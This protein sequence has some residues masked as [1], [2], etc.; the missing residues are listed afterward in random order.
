[1]S[2]LYIFNYSS[3]WARTTILNHNIFFEVVTLSSLSASRCSQSHCL[4][5]SPTSQTGTSTSCGWCAGTQFCKCWASREHVSSANIFLKSELLNPAKP[6]KP[7]SQLVLWLALYL[8]ISILLKHQLWLSTIEFQLYYLWHVNNY[9]ST[10]IQCII[11]TILA[12]QVLAA[13]VYWR[14]RYHQDND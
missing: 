1:M 5:M 6:S 9:K 3:N 10:F 7:V 14:L 8:V 12:C 4:S 13:K 2:Y 11:Y